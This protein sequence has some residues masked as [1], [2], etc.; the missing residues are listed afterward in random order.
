MPH[1]LDYL[2]HHAPYNNI[3]KDAHHVGDSWSDDRIGKN[4]AVTKRHWFC[5]YAIPT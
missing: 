3:W 1:K 4:L 2:Y 5:I